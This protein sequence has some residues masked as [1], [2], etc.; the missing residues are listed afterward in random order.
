MLNVVIL[1]KTLLDWN[2]GP[3]NTNGGGRLSTVDLLLK[4][5]CFAKEVNNIFNAEKR[6]SELFSTRRSTVLRLSLQ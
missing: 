1:S 2:V 3:R 4:V 6:L 5:T